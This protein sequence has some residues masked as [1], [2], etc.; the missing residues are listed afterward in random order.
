MHEVVKIIT[1]NQPNINCANNIAQ[2]LVD[3]YE[4]AIYVQLVSMW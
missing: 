3:S 1:T 4:F 2:Y